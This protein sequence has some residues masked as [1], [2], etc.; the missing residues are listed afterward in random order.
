[1]WRHFVMTSVGVLGFMATV[2]AAE[3]DQKAETFPSSPAPQVSWAS[4]YVGANGG[5]G[6]NARDP[7]MQVIDLT[8]NGTDRL[9]GAYAGGGFGGVQAGYNWQGL[10]DP[11]FVLGVEAD[12][13]Y[14][15]IAGNL[16]AL[17]AASFEAHTSLNSF[18]TLRG[19]VGYA[20][21]RALFYA[22]AG[23]A[24]GDVEDTVIYKNGLGQS[25]SFDSSSTRTGYVAGGGVGLTL[26]PNWSLKVDYQLLHLES[27]SAFETFAGGAFTDEVR[28]TDPGHDYHTIRV[29]LNYHLQASNQ[30]LK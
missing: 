1:M 10:L 19:R 12:L 27:L 30:L 2:N 6:W 4:F 24:F 13:E 22:T 3:L 5:Y 29:G 14:A 23:V 16:K 18:G 8:S 25:S 7:D 11:G 28:T 20:W 9:D 26:T 17:P 21:D 15:G